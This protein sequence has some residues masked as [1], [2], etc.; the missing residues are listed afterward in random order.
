M[1]AAPTLPVSGSAPAHIAS[2]T[3]AGAQ[4]LSEAW[5][6]LGEAREYALWGKPEVSRLVAG[7]AL[8]KHRLGRRLRL[9]GR[10]RTASP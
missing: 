3:T 1:S 4:L 2:A 7:V 10:Q 6:V 8:A 5:D 9:E